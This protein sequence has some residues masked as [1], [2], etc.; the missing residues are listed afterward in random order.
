MSQR[1]RQRPIP[2]PFHLSTGFPKCVQLWHYTSTS[3]LRSPTYATSAHAKRPGAFHL[4]R[5]A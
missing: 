3:V 4:G 5:L 2:V 1:N